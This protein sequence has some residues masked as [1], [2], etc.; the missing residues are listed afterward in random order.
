MC[1]SLWVLQH[2]NKDFFQK[3]SKLNFD[4]YFYLSWRAEITLASSI[5]PTLV[6]DTSMERSSRVLQHGNQKYLIVGSHV[7]KMSYL[8]VSAV[9]FCKEFLDY[10]VHIDR[11]YHAINKHSSSS[12]HYICVNYMHIYV[13]TSLHHWFWS[14]S[15][16]ETISG[17]H[18]RPFKG[19]YLTEI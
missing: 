14:I 17:M 1:R 9:M 8:S 18:R 7:G 19:R 16:L 15:Y 11:C 13:S 4:L 5:S 6:N 3:R 12:Q 10:I 2:G